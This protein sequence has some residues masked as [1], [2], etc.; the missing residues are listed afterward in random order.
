M[1][2][3]VLMSIHPQYAVAIF[4]GRKRY[5]LR[6]SRPQFAA[7]TIVWLYATRP[8]AA[9]VGWFEA[10]DVISG[11][12]IDLW[13]GLRQNLGVNWSDYRSYLSGCQRAF[14]IEIRH[15]QPIP[16]DVPMPPGLRVPQ[17]YRYLRSPTTFTHMGPN[18]RDPRPLVG[19]GRTPWKAALE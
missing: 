19:L 8:R 2:E 6:R 18:S 12:P 16:Q 4:E 9:I 14:A 17:S 11:K 3:Q 13:L 5:E 10:G 1:V 7:G 15:S